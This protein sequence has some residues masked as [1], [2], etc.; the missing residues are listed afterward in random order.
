MSAT[1][2]TPRAHWMGLLARLHFYIGLFIGPFLFIAA[3][4]GTLYVLTPQ[5]ENWW[6][7][8]ALTTTSVG[9]PQPIAA[10]IE[11][12]QKV[13]GSNASLFAVR[14]GLNPGSTSRVMY[15]EAGLGSSESR[16]IFIDPV[17]LAVKGD[18]TVYGTS[19]VLPLRTTLDYLHRNLL[20]GDIG[21]NYS[22][23][24]ASWMWIAA[25]AGIGLWLQQ[26][27]KL[28]KAKGS[29]NEG[30]KRQRNHSLMGLWIAL[31]LLFFS[32]TGLT[33]SKWAGDR[34]DSLRTEL[35]WVTPSVSRNLQTSACNTPVAAHHDH[36]AMQIANP[37][38]PFSVAP[39]AFDGILTIARKGGI[40]A[41]LLEI[42]PPHKADQ[43]WLVREVDRSWPTQVDTV[44]IDGATGHITSR[45]DFAT[46]PLIAKLIRW[47]IDAHMG[48]LFGL[49][50][51]LILAA[52]GITMM[53]LII[54]G[55]RLWWKRR[56]PA[57][58]PLKTL[59]E[60]WLKLGYLGRALVLFIAGILG[61][62][63]PV[64]GVSLIGFILIDIVRTLLATADRREVQP[65]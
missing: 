39:D 65:G 18:M 45:A 49:P 12:A 44:A 30:L 24:A 25:L 34:I 8:D 21:R 3:L 42:R 58:A 6:Y 17:T 54:T 15:S 13:V 64:M 11:A 52:F 32:A 63:L 19:G 60:S 5:I 7:S 48:V 50:N 55:Y 51:Q 31:G 16:A 40:D 41:N 22:E 56:P 47:G 37:V 46:F 27:R 35:N 62:C 9:E 61:W 2:A 26:R 20:L 38:E 36:N 53:L 1:P 33:W 57:G 43:A 28:A 14:P 23:L 10:Q 29:K 4:T 59:L